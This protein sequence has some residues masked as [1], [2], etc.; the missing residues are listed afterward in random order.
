MH[1]GATQM[2]FWKVRERILRGLKR[3]GVDSGGERA[4]PAGG[5]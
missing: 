5:L 4:E 2:R 3:V 1:I